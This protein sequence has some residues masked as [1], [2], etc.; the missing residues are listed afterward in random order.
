MKHKEIIGFSIEALLNSDE[1][2]YLLSQ[3]L[4]SIIKQCKSTPNESS[5]SEIFENELY[6]VIRAFFGIEINFI[7]EVGENIVGHKFNGRMDAVCN[8]LIIEYKHTSKLQSEKDK[9]EATKQIVN[10]LEQL[11]ENNK[12]YRGILTDGV[13]IKYFYYN[14]NILQSTPFSNI[15]I[16]D[17][18]T[19]IKSLIKVE[20]K[21]FIPQN[22]VRDFKF[23]SKNSNTKDL[24]KCLFEFL[25]TGITEKTY[26]LFKEWEV[27]FHLSENDK[28][29]NLDIEKRRKA[30]SKIFEVEIENNQIEYKALFALQT[31]YAIIIKLIACKVISKIT[32][33]ESIRYFSDLT[34]IN[35]EELRMFLEKLEDGYSFATG[36]IRNLLEGDFFSWYCDKAQWNEREF[37]AIINIIKTLEEYGNS[38]FKYEYEAID[39]FKDLYMEIMPNEVRH[40]LGEYFTPSW[41]ADYVTENSINAVNKDNWRA[42]DPCCGSGI[43]TVTLIK[44]II[45]TKNIH[46]MTSKEKSKLLFNIL[47]RVSGIDINP[48]SVLTARVSYMLAIAPLIGDNKIEIPVYLGDSA[49]IPKLVELDGVNCY[50]YSIATQKAII[51]IN[52]PCSFVKSADFVEKMSYIQALVKTGESEIVYNEFVDNINEYERSS[53]VLK[54]LRELSDKLVELHI[55]NWDGIWIR[56]VTN[57]MLVARIKNMDIIIGNPPWVKWEFLPQKYA[58]KIKSICIDRHLF[59]GQ[60]YMGAISLNICALI[61]NVTASTWLN[62]DG[63]LAFLMPRTIMTQDSYSGFRNF[64]LDYKKEERLY[65]QSIDDWSKSGDP[66]I[67]TKEKFLTYYYKR[68]S[69]DYTKG[70]PIKYVNKKRTYKITDINRHRNFKDVEK[71]FEFKDGIATQVDDKRTGFS[72]VES[73]DYNKTDEFKNII[74]VCD[75]KARSGVEFT[76]AEIYFIEPL[77][78]SNDKNSFM[79]KNCTFKASKYKALENSKFELETKYVRPVIKSPNIKA[80]GI[81]ESNNY[82]I[83]P[84]DD[85]NV[86]SVEL[87]V[88]RRDCK[89]MTSY[90]IEYM[91]TIKKQS[92]KSQQIS[93]GKA[94]YSLSKVGRYT[95]AE[96]IVVFRDNTNL[97]SAVVSPVLTPWGNKVMPICAKHSPYISMDKNNRYISKDESYY[98]CGILNSKIVREYFKATFSSRSFSINFNIKLPLYDETND[99]HKN[100]CDLSKLAH[101]VTTEEEKNRLAEK[102]NKTYVE[103]CK[104]IVVKDIQDEV[105]TK[106]IVEV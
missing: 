10:Y 7:K 55:N 37:L 54:S 67:F 18:D 20:N 61:A 69:I 33:N 24:A 5:L 58:E 102:I 9:N 41:L 77:G 38:A 51:N 29:K 49:N 82:C 101:N 73:I 87:T 83:F 25:N 16:S 30:L 62:N 76:P 28:G 47:N 26:M 39:I 53:G 86:E 14:N 105:D 80:F 46:D 94:F 100:I 84:Y 97:V 93:K 91:N 96:N 1:Y 6:Y 48:L 42:I 2:K 90:L 72:M 17:I 70:I 19:I 65:L 52:L 32:F 23:N 31:T 22:I 66:F 43:F 50:K 98:I 11:N 13:K 71:C 104:S 78:E 3:T 56:I 95:F 81:E 21:Q 36:G 35:S 34:I 106:N 103:M 57:F 45:G 75:Y 92:E 27:L 44:K 74:G 68:D 79:F 15:K 4:T 88:L 60:T 59:S 12:Q 85:K 99:Y 8:D 89:K 64:Y 40:S 63:I